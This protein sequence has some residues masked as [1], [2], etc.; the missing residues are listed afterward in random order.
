MHIPIFPGHRKFLG[1]CIYKLRNNVSCES[2]FKNPEHQ[3]GILSG[4][5]VSCKSVEKS[6]SSRLRETPESSDFTRFHSKQ[7][8]IRTSSQTGNSVHR[9]TFHFKLGIVTPTPERIK[10]LVSAIKNLHRSQ[11]WAKDFLHLLGIMASCLELIPNARLFMRPTQLHL[12]AFWSPASLDLEASIPVTQHLKSHLIWVNPAN[13]MG[14]DL[15]NRNT[16]KTTIFTDASK[17]VYGGRVG[18]QYFQGIWSESQKKLHNNL[19]KL[20]AVFL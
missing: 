9:G 10:K 13:T 14:A 2:S 19:L 17:Q 16:L 6:A 4:G 1:F 15:Y 18:N 7:R 3:T 8:E 12:L 11:N 20:E 5:L